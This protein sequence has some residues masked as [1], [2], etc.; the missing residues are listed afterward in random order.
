MDSIKNYF[1]QKVCAAKLTI[2]EI[3]PEAVTSKIESGDDFLLI[4]IREDNEWDIAHIPAAIHLGRGILDRDIA[5]NTSDPQSEIVLY[6]ASGS[7]SAVAADLL[8]EMGY[9]NVLSMKG[10]FKAWTSQS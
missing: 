5:K 2:Q 7:R 10:G 9:N 4:D 1:D 8:Q 6:C 3:E